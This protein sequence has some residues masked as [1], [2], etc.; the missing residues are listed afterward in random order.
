MEPPKH[1]VKANSFKSGLY[2]IRRFQVHLAEG[3][4]HPREPLAKAAVR[5]HPTS[6][7]LSRVRDEILGI[8]FGG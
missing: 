7:H 6:T 1:V 2:G 4:A 5:G 8:G 3:S